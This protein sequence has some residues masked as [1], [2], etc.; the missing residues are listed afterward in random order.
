MFEGLEGVTNP[1]TL[2]CPLS[3]SSGLSSPKVRLLSFPA[4]CW[5]LASI[6]T[7]H[8]FLS[9]RIAEFPQMS[10]AGKRHEYFECPF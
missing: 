4:A 7:F 1:R 2:I 3:A 10:T 8:F 5:A 9:L 6:E